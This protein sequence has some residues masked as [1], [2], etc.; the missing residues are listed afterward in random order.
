M[1]ARPDPGRFRRVLS[2]FC[3]G[4]VVVTAATDD[5]PVGLTCQSFSA[6]S[7]DPPLV[8]VAAARRPWPEPTPMM[9]RSVDARSLPELSKVDLSAPG[10]LTDPANRNAVHVQS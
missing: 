4:I 9:D 8:L 7:L 5:G 10:A 1:S 6:L 3:T 2:H